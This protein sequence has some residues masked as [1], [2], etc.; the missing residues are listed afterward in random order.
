M[1][2][3]ADAAGSTEYILDTISQSVPGSKWAVGTEANLVK[4][5]QEALPDHKI[6]SLRPEGSF[7]R[8]MNLLDETA[9][10]HTLQQV[11]S[12]QV[13][14][15]VKVDDETAKMARIAVDRMLA[16]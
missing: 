13:A 15:Q 16:L 2:D 11:E 14:N 8:D 10:L 5:M 1:V 9:L 4:R 6:V 12:G 7:C 3:A